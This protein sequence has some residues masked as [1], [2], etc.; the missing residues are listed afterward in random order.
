MH[1]E[2]SWPCSAARLL[3][4]MLSLVFLLLCLESNRMT[5]DASVLS[6]NGLVQK[7]GYELRALLHAFTVPSYCLLQ[8]APS[9]LEVL[10]TARCPNCCHLLC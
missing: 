8:A 9:G 1:A 4:S 5:K 7:G 3:T 6:S 10:H 2:L